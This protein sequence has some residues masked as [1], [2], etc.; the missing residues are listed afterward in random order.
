VDGARKR[1]RKRRRESLRDSACL[2]AK[3]SPR[4]ASPVVAQKISA[5][6][7]FDIFDHHLF[8]ETQR[9]DCTDNC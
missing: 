7:H 2:T 9:F 6:G 3:K 1:K 8:N 4:R 5:M